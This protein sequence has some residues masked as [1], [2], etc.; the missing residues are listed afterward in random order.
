MPR[1]KENRK[2][3]YPDNH[4]L[5]EDGDLITDYSLIRNR[6]ESVFTL[7]DYKLSVSEA[8]SQHLESS[9]EGKGYIMQ[10]S[11]IAKPG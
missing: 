9:Q 1:M 7:L 8:K 5:D 3:A 11:T 4:Y 2:K 10:T 6:V